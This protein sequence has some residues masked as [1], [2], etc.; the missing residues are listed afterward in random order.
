MRR[1]AAVVAVVVPLSLLAVVVGPGARVEAQSVEG[2][3]IHFPVAGTVTLTWYYS[4]G[5]DPTLLAS[6][7][8]YRLNGT[9]VQL[10][11]L[12][13]G[14]GCYTREHTLHVSA[15]DVLQV[16]LKSDSGWPTTCLYDRRHYSPPADAQSRWTDGTGDEVGWVHWEDMLMG[17]PCVGA[18]GDYDDVETRIRFT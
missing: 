8:G 4:C 5:D 14:G 16:W 7:Y 17:P 18:D 1:L 12:L 3:G 10:G 9:D 15:G 2:D 6:F 11:A 13:P